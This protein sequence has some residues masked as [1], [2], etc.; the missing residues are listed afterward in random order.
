MFRYREAF[1]RD[2]RVSQTDGGTGGETDG[3]VVFRNSAN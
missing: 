1:R 2:S 3:H